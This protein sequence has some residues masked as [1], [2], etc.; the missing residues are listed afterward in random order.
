MIFIQATIYPITPIDAEVG[1]IIKFSWQGNQAFKNR[2]I[3][4]E[5]ET[6]DVVYDKTIETFKYE[7]SIDLTVAALENGKKYNAFITVFD[8]DNNE[9]DIQSIGA[10]FLCLKTPS[11][12]FGNISDDSV[13]SSS[14]YT[15][16]LNYSQE[17]GELLDSWSMTLYSISHTILSSTGTKYDTSDLSHTFQGFSNRNQYAVRAVGKTING[18]DVDTGFVTISVTYSIKD[19]FS[20]LDPINVKSQG[21]IHL[22]SNIVSSEGHAKNEPYYIQG[23]FVDLTNNELSY[24]EGYA[25]KGDFSFAMVFYGAEPNDEVLTMR[26]GNDNELDISVTYRLGKFGVDYL[27]C[28]YELRVTTRWRTSVYYSNIID[29]PEYDDKIGVLITRENNYYNIE[30]INF[31]GSSNEFDKTKIYYLDG[32]G[33]YLVNEDDNYLVMDK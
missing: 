8:K 9:S 2:C 22:R 29:L 7:H 3:I 19:I 4:K 13:I 23:E 32:D 27:V 31:G 15:F 11:F 6:N 24:T 16:T 1:G 17:N 10:S 25:L 18:V 20:L 21:G 30:I 14:S 28:Q 33:M 12:S 5:N 26:T